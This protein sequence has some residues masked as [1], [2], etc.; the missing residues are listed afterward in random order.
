M[1]QAAKTTFNCINDRMHKRVENLFYENYTNNIVTCK[2]IVY[3]SQPEDCLHKELGVVFIS[4]ERL[5]AE[6]SRKF[7]GM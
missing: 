4:R 7:P 5:M 2:V 6:S 3:Y 1:T